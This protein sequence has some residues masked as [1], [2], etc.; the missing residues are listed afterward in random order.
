[1]QQQ[2]EM[3][4]APIA[5]R[6]DPLTSHEAAADITESGVR[7]RQMADVLTAVKR[8]PGRTSA[9]LGSVS[10]FDRWVAARRLP[11]LEKKGLVVRGEARKCRITSKRSITWWPVQA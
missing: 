4:D 5:R 10:R 8:Y 1:M 11:E 6:T 2:Q 9:E 7:G 3:F